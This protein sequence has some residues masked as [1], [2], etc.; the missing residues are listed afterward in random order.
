MV[1]LPKW[2]VT[3]HV[4][5]SEIVLR[6][7]SDIAARHTFDHIRG[8]LTESGAFLYLDD[9]TGI[10]LLARREEIDAVMLEQLP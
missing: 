9:D 5:N 4:S 2:A 10:R 8:K 7:R 3:V 6:Y 1:E